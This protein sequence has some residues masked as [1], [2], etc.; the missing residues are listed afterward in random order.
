MPN[1]AREEEDADGAGEESTRLEQVNTHILSYWFWGACKAYFKLH[2]LCEAVNHF[3]E[4]CPCHPIS[5]LGEGQRLA[6]LQ[7][8]S[9]MC[10]GR[11]TPSFADGQVQDVLEDM[12]GA[13]H[14]QLLLFCSGLTGDDLQKVLVDWERGRSYI[15]HTLLSKFAFWKNPT[16]ALRWWSP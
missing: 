2:L 15:Q 5:F 14:A 6:D 8:S 12:A 10:M 13:S 9:C 3:A 16:F 7:C 4:S 1:N 11:Q